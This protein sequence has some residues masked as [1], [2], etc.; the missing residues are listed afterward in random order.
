MP[1]PI[2]AL[3]FGAGNRGAEAYGT[4][5][6]KHPDNIQFV[7]VAEPNPI[8]RER[9]TDAH[10]IPADL[11]FKDWQEALK[12]K[13]I[14][15]VIVNATQDY[16][17]HDSAL[18]ALD[19]GYDM[20]LEKPIA[21]TL[22]ETLDI[23]R[24]A[25][26]SGQLLM[27]CHVLRYT[28]FFQKVNEILKS[29][30]LGQI[31]NISHSENVSY[32]HMAHSYVR[33]NWRNRELSAPMILAKCC[34]DLDLLYWFLGEKVQRLSS[35]GNLRHFRAENAPKG[36]PE[37]CTDGCPAA[38]TCPYFAP[39]I[40]LESY[41]I[42]KAVSQTNN[43]LLRFIGKL[44]L[45][46]PGL[47]KTLGKIIPPVRLLTEY[48]GWPRSTITENP[49]DDQAVL[50]A[51]RIG[52][53]GRCV[54]HCDNNVVDH[55]IV[56]MTFES[57]ITATL[58][59]HGHSHEEG[60]T[61]RVDGSQATLLGKFSYSQAWLEVH[62]HALAPLE[63]YTFPSEVDQT[64]GH[65]GGDA[66]LMHQFVK[67]IRGEK[68]PLTSARDSLESHLMAFAT[69]EARIENKCINMNQYRSNLDWRE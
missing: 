62:D 14:A 6:L 39:R 65:G 10:H 54:Y 1:D 18:A 11:Q 49:K 67:A 20:L 36:A 29:G 68:P 32:F 4:Y 59:M 3:L 64:A 50:E 21:P 47:A 7:A 23:V 31:I 52:P 38:G 2:R 46:Q 35:V 13:K 63:R 48:S 61:L 27:I 22:Q 28:D 24:K 40:Y 30:R 8:R 41:P 56:S 25:E 33:G 19:A 9:F 66:G 51:L 16:M 26:E 55:Q 58:T 69:D 53:Y 17:H 5:A 45:N 42:K 57:G 60:R 44:S 12:G 15:D 34:H 37:R 43:P